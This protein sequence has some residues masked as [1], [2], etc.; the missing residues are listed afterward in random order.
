MSELTIREGYTLERELKRLEESGQIDPDWRS[1]ARHPGD[2]CKSPTHLFDSVVQCGNLMPCPLH[3]EYAR[4][5]EQRR[6]DEDG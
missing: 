4:K 5:L 2:R 1:Q 6:E 3:R